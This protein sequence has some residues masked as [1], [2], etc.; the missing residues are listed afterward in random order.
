MKGTVV[1]QNALFMMEMCSEENQEI[2]IK[3]EKKKVPCPVFFPILKEE[4]FE[5]SYVSVCRLFDI[6]L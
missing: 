4:L 5:V 1:L 2:E 6:S 3:F